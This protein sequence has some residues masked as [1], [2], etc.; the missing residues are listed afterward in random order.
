MDSYERHNIEKILHNNVACMQVPNKVIR[1]S[2]VDA[3]SW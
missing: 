3:E 1:F 2:Y